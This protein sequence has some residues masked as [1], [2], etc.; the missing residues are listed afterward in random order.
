MAVT[1]IKLDRVKDY[2]TKAVHHWNGIRANARNITEQAKAEHYQDGYQTISETLLGSLPE[3][4]TS[5]RAEKVQD[6]LDQGIRAWR[7]KQFQAKTLEEQAMAVHYQ[8]TFQTTRSTLL[9][10]QLPVE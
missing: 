9:G 3:T 2:L 10:S 4:A 7:V 8:D 5:L 6:Y 1:A